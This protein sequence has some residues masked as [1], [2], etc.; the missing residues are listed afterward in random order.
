METSIIITALI[1]G[2]LSGIVITTLNYFLNKKK[3]DAEITKLKA[4]TEK[5]IHETRN[6]SNKIE[7][8]LLDYEEKVIYNNQS[9]DHFDFI[10]KKVS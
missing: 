2:L 8:N 1:S 6:L 4:E 9:P 10:S 3:T 5:L 7:E